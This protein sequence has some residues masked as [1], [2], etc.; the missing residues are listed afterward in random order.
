M[1]RGTTPTHKFVFSDDFDL[2]KVKVIVITYVQNNLTVLEK[3]K[4]D[5]TF[6]KSDPSVAMVT[7]TQEE[8]LKF[9]PYKTVKIQ[10]RAV[11]DD[12]TALAT[13]IFERP[14]DDVLNEEVL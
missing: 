2:T 12:G 3:T 6:D 10:L 14:C 11:T 4:E 9:D 8:T 1:I 7:L 13:D 5:L